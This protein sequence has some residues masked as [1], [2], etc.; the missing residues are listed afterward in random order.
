MTARAASFTRDRSNWT[1]KAETCAAW[2]RD[3]CRGSR[4]QASA[5]IRATASA[6]IV[7][8]S[9]ASMMPGAEGATDH[10][11]KGCIGHGAMS[12]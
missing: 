1:T 4:I 5:C 8:K 10:G 11:G 3:L 12:G 9:N 7:S 2:L 6:R